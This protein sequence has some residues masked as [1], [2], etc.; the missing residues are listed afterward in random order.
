MRS[1]ST[2]SVGSLIE[3]IVKVGGSYGDVIAVLRIAKDKG[4]LRDQ[5]AIDPLPNSKRMYY[6]EQESDDS[7]AGQS[8]DVVREAD[9]LITGKTR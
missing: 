1:T 5:L 2:T 4:Y 7:D 9:L 8:D 3:G 6:R